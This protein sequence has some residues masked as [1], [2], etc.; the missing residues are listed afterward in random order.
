M[1]SA[2]I[3]LNFKLF[4]FFFCQLPSLLIIAAITHSDLRNSADL[5]DLIAPHLHH[6][7]LT[8]Q[9]LSSTQQRTPASPVAWSPYTAHILSLLAVSFFPLLFIIHLPLFPIREVCLVTG[10]IPF[11]IAH[12]YVRTLFPTL[13]PAFVE[14]MPFVIIRLGAFKERM[15]SK[16]GL[17]GKRHPDVMG[18][19]DGADNKNVPFP[20]SMVVRRVM[21]DD[22]LSDECWNSEIREVQLWEN[23]RF[24]GMSIY[25]S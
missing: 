15:F 17:R 14:V 21:D 8:P 22:R 7:R 2:W 13:W 3:P 18:D 24:G 6:L 1:Q 23:E 11:V 4:S 20:L 19:G 10:L 25:L 5:H 12:P 16:L 9:H